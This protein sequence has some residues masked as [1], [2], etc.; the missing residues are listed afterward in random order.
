MLL[1]GR[2]LTPDNVSKTHRHCLPKFVR[3]PSLILA[4]RL[5]ARI[6]RHNWRQNEFAIQS[7]I[8][9]CQRVAIRS[10]KR[11][12]LH[13]LCKALVFYTCFDPGSPR[14]FECW[15]DIPFLAKQINAMYLVDDDGLE[16]CRYDT[17]LNALA[18]LQRMEAILCV[19]EYCHLTKRNKLS[20]VFLMPV[21]FRMFGFKDSETYQL[22]KANRKSLELPAEKRERTEKLWAKR[23]GNGVRAQIRSK[24][25]KRRIEQAQRK[26]STLPVANDHDVMRGVIKEITAAADHE[27]FE[28]RFKTQA[29]DG[30]EQRSRL[31]GRFST[32]DVYVLQ[33]ELRKAFPELIGEE[34]ERLVDD[35]LKQKL[36]GKPPPH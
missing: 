33:A 19:R 2:N 18:E 8:S 21:F 23:V 36:S 16:V 12:T 14:Q 27:A 29:T 25:A 7:R 5:F 26:F 35:E 20:R 24:A 30:L 6:D 11:E 13:A 34:L 10:E 22:L 15:A 28:R 9:N 17:V 32:A 1:V 31:R 3:T 4:R